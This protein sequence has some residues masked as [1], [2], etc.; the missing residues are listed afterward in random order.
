MTPVVLRAAG[1]CHG[2]PFC[3]S[4]ASDCRHARL[5]GGHVAPS[6]QTSVNKKPFVTEVIRSRKGRK[7]SLGL[8]PLTPS[9]ERRAGV[10]VLI[11]HGES[12]F[13]KQDRFTGLKD[14]PLTTNGVREAIAAG[15]TLQSKGFHCDIAFTS[16]LKR[17]QQSLQLILRELHARSVPVFDDAALNERNYGELAGLTRDAARARWGEAQVHQWRRSYDVAPPGGESLAMTAARTMPFFDERVRPLLATGKR[18]LIVAHGNSVRSIVMSLDRLTPEQ[19]VNVS[20]ATGTIL[21]YRL[22][23][24]GMIVERTEIPV[25]RHA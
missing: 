12:E 16:K 10:L 15:R 11:R 18:V 9:V 24:L 25:S 13:N 21:I 14:P 1:A 8:T 19:I 6:Y 20:F 2:D 22:D 4:Q 23:V 3:G 17:A 7:S 5:A